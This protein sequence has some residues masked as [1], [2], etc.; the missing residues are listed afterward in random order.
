[1][2]GQVK[3]EGQTGFVMVVGYE[4]SF[5][6]IRWSVIQG[7]M[8]PFLIIDLFNEIGNPFSTSARLHP[9]KKNLN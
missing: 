4:H 6:F 5:K 7:R 9:H 2:F 3:L 1:M 8:Q